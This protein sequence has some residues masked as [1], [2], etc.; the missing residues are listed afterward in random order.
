MELTRYTQTV[1]QAKLHF[2]HIFDQNI[3]KLFAATWS[4]MNVVKDRYV[5]EFVKSDADGKLVN[6]EGLPY[7]LD[8]YVLEQID[9]IQTCLGTKTV[10]DQI[11][12]AGFA[13]GGGSPFS[14]MMYTTLILSQ[15]GG[16]D[17]MMWEADLNV[18]LSEECAVSANYT[19][20]TACGDLALVSS[21][22][23]YIKTVTNRLTETL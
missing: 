12:Q 13:T 1:T 2:P 22:I 20:R 7:S 8:L 21:L 4:D 3:E 23:E 6:S 17:R 10:R 19:P 15:I 11:E 18:F 5:A 14:Q 9:F 16:E